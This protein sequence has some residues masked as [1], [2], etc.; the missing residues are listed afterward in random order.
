MKYSPGPWEVGI[1]PDGDLNVH[2][3]DAH[4]IYIGNMEG[5]C[6]T[7]HANARLIAAAPELLA[8][9]N[10]VEWVRD[11]EGN[12]H[13]PWCYALKEI[14]HFEDCKRQQALAKC[15]VCREGLDA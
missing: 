11:V 12:F 14:D 4:C 13:C 5:T 8:L 2:T 15:A 1:N 9:V 6:A 7:C 10:A 3:G